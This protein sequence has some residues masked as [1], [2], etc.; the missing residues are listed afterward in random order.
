MEYF[1]NSINHVITVYEF[2]GSSGTR[3]I[4][5]PGSQHFLKGTGDHDLVV[6]SKE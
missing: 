3:C 5:N 1:Q 6:L 2:C 4:D